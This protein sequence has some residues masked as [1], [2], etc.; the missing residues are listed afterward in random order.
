MIVD[1]NSR[2]EGVRL[3]RQTDRF[4]HL[5]SAETEI[6]IQYEPNHNLS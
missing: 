4:H 5:K 6:Q 2:I 3:E 1:T